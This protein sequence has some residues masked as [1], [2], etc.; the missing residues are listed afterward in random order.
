SSHVILAAS[1]GEGRDNRV[2]EL[3]AAAETIWDAHGLIT[4]GGVLHCTEALSKG[5]VEKAVQAYRL[6]GLSAAADVLSEAVRLP[7]KDQDEAEE[8]LDKAYDNAIVSDSALEAQINSRLPVDRFEIHPQSGES[9]VSSAR[10]AF[11][12]NGAQAVRLATLKGK[13]RLQHQAHHRT[14]MAFQELV[15]HWDTGGHEALSSLLDHKDDAVRVEA[16]AYLIRFDRAPAIKVLNEL[17]DKK[18][19]VGLIADMALFVLENGTL[20]NPS[21]SLRPE[22]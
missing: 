10:R 13:T 9:P 22:P 14:E 17:K 2:M 19:P 18:P 1:A 16:A 15:R 3:E 7:K 11:I 5:E 8:R 6:F 21:Q 20:A 4:N 12:E